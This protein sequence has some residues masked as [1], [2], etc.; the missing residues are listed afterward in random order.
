MKILKK[1]GTLITTQDDLYLSMGYKIEIV[2]DVDFEDPLYRIGENIEYDDD[3][4]I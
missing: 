3:I 2:D 1:A 4:K